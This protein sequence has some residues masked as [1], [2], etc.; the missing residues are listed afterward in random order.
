[1]PFSSGLFWGSLLLPKTHWSFLD[2]QT[3]PPILLPICNQNFLH[4]PR[5]SLSFILSSCRNPYIPFL[6]PL[7]Q[8]FS[9]RIGHA[10]ISSGRPQLISS[11]LLSCEPSSR[12]RP[13]MSSSQVISY[14]FCKI[15]SWEKLWSFLCYYQAVWK[16]N[17][18]PWTWA[19]NMG[20]Q[21]SLEPDWGSSF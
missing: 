17:A 18:G 19:N 4:L 5:S 6:C 20:S 3:T 10:L 14:Q 21:E 16:G 2:P 7:T 15:E 12:Q 1:M 8:T 11:P 13:H 9:K